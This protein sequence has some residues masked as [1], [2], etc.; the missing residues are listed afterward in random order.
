MLAVTGL[1]VRLRRRSGVLRV[2]GRHG[3]RPRPSLGDLQPCHRLLRGG[4]RPIRRPVAADPHHQR[5]SAG[6]AAGAADLHDADHR[7]DHVRS[8]ASSWRCTRTPACRGCCWSAC[9]CWRS[10]TTGSCRT[11][12]PSSAAAAAH[13]QHQPGHARTALRYPGDPGVRPRTLRAQTIRR[14]EPGAVGSALEAGRWQA[15]MLPV[16]TLVINISSVALIWFGGLRIDAR[17]DA[18]R[19][20]DRIPVLLHADPDGRVAGDVHPG[21]P[22]ARVGVRRTDHRGAGDHAGASPAPQHPC[23][24]TAFDGEMRLDGPRSAIRA[25]R[26]PGAARYFVDRHGPAPRRRSSARQV[27]ASRR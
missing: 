11:C 21:A 7:A 17:P 5:C 22:A 24:P 19:L 10:P 18:G 16:T 20:A 2:A 27:R 15:L 3:V 4:D 25:P 14:G 9:R 8:A 12:C 23:D 6:S 26:Q 1:Q 13:R